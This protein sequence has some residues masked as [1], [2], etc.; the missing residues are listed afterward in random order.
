MARPTIQRADNC[1][2]RLQKDPTP[3]RVCET[4]NTHK[5]CDQTRLWSKPRHNNMQNVSEQRVLVENLEAELLDLQ[6]EINVP[7]TE[8]HEDFGNYCQGDLLQ[9]N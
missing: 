3:K 8:L 2:R 7:N 6:E 9:T 1:T 5:V 4:T